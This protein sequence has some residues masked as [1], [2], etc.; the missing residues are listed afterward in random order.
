MIILKNILSF[1]TDPK[2]TRMLLLGGIIVL[3]AL[4][5]RQCEKTA[6]AKGEVDRVTNNWK[7]SLDTLENYTKA[8]GNAA[9]EIM[10]LNLTLD[11]LNEK[12]EYEKNKPPITVIETETVVKEV[13]VEVPVTVIDTIIGDFS[14]A[15]SI[16]DSASWGKSS[17]SID[18]VVPYEIHDTLID[19]GNATIDLNQ[20]IWLSASMSRNSKTK[21]VFVNLETDYPGTTFNSAKGILVDQNTPGFRSLQFQNRKTFGLGLQLGLGYN[22]NGITPYV[23]IGLNYSPKFLQW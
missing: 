19:F 16:S 11:E 8:N 3:I 21:E 22:T 15:F 1:I 20:N 7:A 9:A 4:F 14:S 10:A 12:L 23:G 6:I 5:L 2:N 17:R 13:I 18:F